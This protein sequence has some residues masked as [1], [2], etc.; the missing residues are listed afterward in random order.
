MT[1][2]K[3]HRPETIAASHGVA[4]DAAFG[5]V[6]PPLYLS[7]T[8]QFEGYDKPGPYDYGRGNNPTRDQFASA[9][10][11]LEEGAGAVITSS[12][13][14][15]LDLLVGRLT[16]A[17]LVIAPHDAYAGTLRLLQARANRGHF[18]LCL[19]DQSDDAAVHQ[20][21]DD[22]PA[23]LLIESP[24]NP[25][26]RVVDIESRAAWAHQAGAEVAVDNT[27]LSP[28]LQQPIP[29]GADYVFHSTTK[30]LNGHSD[31]IGGAVVASDRQ[32]FESLKQWANIVGATGSPFD[33]WL[34]LRG[35][36]TLYAR[37]AVQQKSAMAI[38]VYLSDHPAVKAVHYPGL[39][40]HASHAIANRQQS[41]F[42]AMLS[43]ELHGGLAA[44]RNFL[45]SVEIFTLAESLGGVESL[46]AHPATMTH[47]DMTDEARTLAGISDSL[48]RISVGLEATSDLIAGLYS[49]LDAC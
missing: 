34:A 14:G 36:R 13:L 9:L 47:V 26:M 41:G 40:T 4:T 20:A 33:S 32:R 1:D 19:I 24:S 15:A 48:L 31:V 10:A 49:G 8:Y 6:V 2:R 3:R 7:T 27:F 25:L 21:L 35:L 42:G 28:A 5:A 46:I 44:V 29:L 37:L 18:R 11:Q 38:A 45:R 22:T 43:F 17:D 23:L 16:P 12:G 30:Y 39:P